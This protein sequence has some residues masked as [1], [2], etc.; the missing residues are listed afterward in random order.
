[1]DIQNYTNKSAVKNKTT[2]FFSMRLNFANFA[3]E[4]LSCNI[5]TE[6]TPTLQRL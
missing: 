1:M 2:I 4:E 5:Y 3:E 6:K